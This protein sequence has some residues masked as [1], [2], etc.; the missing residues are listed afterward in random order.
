MANVT[1]KLGRSGGFIREESLKEDLGILPQKTIISSREKAPKDVKVISNYDIGGIRSCQIGMDGSVLP[2]LVQLRY[3]IFEVGQD[4]HKPV[5]E[6][7]S[8]P[9]LAPSSQVA[10]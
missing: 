9:C 8:S 10:R 7:W 3:Y 6:L 5:R 4:F 2:E 1:E